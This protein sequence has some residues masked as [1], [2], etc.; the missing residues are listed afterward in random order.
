MKSL[1]ISGRLSSVKCQSH[2]KRCRVAWNEWIC[3]V[4]DI[5]GKSSHCRVEVVDYCPGN[6]ITY[7]PMPSAPKLYRRQPPT[8][9]AQAM[10]MPAYALTDSQQAPCASGRWDGGTSTTTETKSACKSTKKQT[11]RS[12]TSV[13]AE[14]VYSA[15]RRP[16]IGRECTRLKWALHA[17]RRRYRDSKRHRRCWRCRWCGVC[18]EVDRLA[19]SHVSR[20][21]HWINIH[22]MYHEIP[23]NTWP[24]LANRILRK[25]HRQSRWSESK[26]KLF[27]EFAWRR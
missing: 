19:A 27:S 11:E 20:T 7:L 17:S 13:G 10:S 21:T 9:R 8:R 6:V 23:R 26:W 14:T 16:G 4:V 25:S 5:G 22:L 18:V 3:W 15:F 12:S 24:V 2:T 1:E